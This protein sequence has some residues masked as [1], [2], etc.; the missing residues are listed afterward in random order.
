MTWLGREQGR[1]R[2]SVERGQSLR[3][4]RSALHWRGNVRLKME[5]SVSNWMRDRVKLSDCLI[6]KETEAEEKVWHWRVTTQ[7][8][9]NLN[10]SFCVRRYS[11][12]MAIVHCFYLSRMPIHASVFRN[13]DHI[14]HKSSFLSFFATSRVNLPTQK[15]SS[16]SHPRYS[17]SW[18]HMCGVDSAERNTWQFVAVEASRARKCV[19]VAGCRS[20]DL[21]GVG[22]SW[23]PALIHAA[24]PLTGFVFQHAAQ[25]KRNQDQKAW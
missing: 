12:T 15:A 9:E 25:R 5:K 10:I 6:K 17:A 16:T 20:P 21:W 14:S 7:Q 1:K 24:P 11:P 18:K 23:K 3:V 8:K 19:V 13:V 4:Q 22:R 2:R